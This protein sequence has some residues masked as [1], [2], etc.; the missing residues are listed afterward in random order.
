MDQ[1][2]LMGIN[3]AVN[4]VIGVSHAAQDRSENVH[5]GGSTVKE[6][7]GVSHCRMGWGGLCLCVKCSEGGQGSQRLS[8]GQ[9]SPWKQAELNWADLAHVI[10][11]DSQL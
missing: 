11:Y 10:Q 7:L 5:Q 1:N 4:K 2:G 9:C 3:E 6:G 8:T